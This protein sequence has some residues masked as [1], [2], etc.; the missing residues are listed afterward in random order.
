MTE[1]EKRD[2]GMLYNAG[3]DPQLLA[4]VRRAKGLCHRYNQLEPMDFAAQREIL[5]S[6]LGRVG[7]GCVI[8]AGS[9]VTH[10]IPAGSV[11]VGNPCRVIKKI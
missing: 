6:L 7:D 11:A 2:A 9:V 5:Q 4:E 10:D 3:A 1:R 8:G